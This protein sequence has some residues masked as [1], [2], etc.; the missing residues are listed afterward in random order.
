MCCLFCIHRC[1]LTSCVVSVLLFVVLCVC[2]IVCVAA[3]DLGLF[4]CGR[5]KGM[6]LLCNGSF[7]PRFVWPQRDEL[8]L[9]WCLF[10]IVDCQGGGSPGMNLLWNGS[11]VEPAVGWECGGR[12]LAVRVTVKEYCCVVPGEG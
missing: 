2:E 9:Q 1:V 7:P 11:R 8:A 5:R 3:V 6:N 12:R 10:G 4:L